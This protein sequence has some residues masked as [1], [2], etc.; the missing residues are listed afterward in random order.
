[1]WLM[2][3]LSFASITS[4]QIIAMMTTILTLVTALIGRRAQVAME[5][6]NRTALFNEIK[7]M[8]LRF[9]NV[10]ELTS[11]SSTQT[12]EI[13]RAAIQALAAWLVESK[14]MEKGIALEI[15]TREISTAAALKGIDLKSISI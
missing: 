10:L 13:I 15:A 9:L 8:A 11:A 6:G 7:E 1:M 3:A 5:V 4:G 14:G 2:F 12:A